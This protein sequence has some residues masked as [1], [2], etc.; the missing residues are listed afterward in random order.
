MR[1]ATDQSD[2]MLATVI[3]SLDGSR[4]GFGELGPLAEELK[5]LTQ[6]RA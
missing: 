3:D 6:E 4:H 2:V 1:P 5:L